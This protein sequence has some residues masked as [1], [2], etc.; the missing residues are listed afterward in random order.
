M[1]PLRKRFFFEAF[2]KIPPKNVATKLEMW[3]LVDNSLK[4]IT[5]FFCGFPYYVKTFCIYSMTLP[6]FFFDQTNSD[7][8]YW[9][10][11][12]LLRMNIDN[13]RREDWGS[14]SE[15]LLIT[16]SA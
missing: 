14:W 13:I 7:Q 3:P 6:E 8:N 11:T 16:Y 15:L 5:L 12:A 9:I 4:K 1:W 10:D 2:K